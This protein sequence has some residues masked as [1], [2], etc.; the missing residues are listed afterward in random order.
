MNDFKVKMM[1]GQEEYALEELDKLYKLIDKAAQAEEEIG[2][3]R[4]EEYTRYGR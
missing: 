2:I 1:P 4:L 3:D